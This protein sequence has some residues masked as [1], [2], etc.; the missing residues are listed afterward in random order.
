MR[1]SLID[2]LSSD[3]IPCMTPQIKPF[4]SKERRVAWQIPDHGPGP[5]MMQPEYVRYNPKKEKIRAKT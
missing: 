2:Q 1:K 4:K 3:Q 5:N